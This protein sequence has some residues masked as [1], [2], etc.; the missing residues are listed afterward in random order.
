MQLAPPFQLIVDSRI[1]GYRRAAD[2]VAM[3]VD[4]LGGRMHDHVR[5]EQQRLLQRRRKKGIV[6]HQQRAGGMRGLRHVADIGDAQQRIGRRLHPHQGRLFG[7]AGGQRGAVGEVDEIHREAAFFC[8]RV[9][10]APSAAVAIVRRQH[11][12]AGRH[13]FQHQRHRRH[14]AGR[15][16]RTGA[17]LQFGQRVAEQVAGRIAAARIVV[18]AL[19]TEAIEAVVARQVQ[20]WHHRPVLGI[21]FDAGTHGGGTGGALA[22]GNLR[23]RFMC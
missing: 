20:R 15:D 4:V 22:H 17:L 1:L 18:R 2:H 13:Q 3:A 19:A 7:E 6:D 23:N 16:H 8:P 10:Q 21:G 11:M 12:A 5:T 9:E 14:A